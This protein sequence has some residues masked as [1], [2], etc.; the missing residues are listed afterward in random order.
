MVLAY[1][2]IFIYNKQSRHQE[3]TRSGGFVIFG[4]SFGK[5]E[6]H[7]QWCCLIFNIRINSNA[8]S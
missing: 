4:H 2:Y 1:I 5:K 6:K 3:T 8:A 7:K